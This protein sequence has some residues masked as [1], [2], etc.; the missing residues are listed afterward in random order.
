[1]SAIYEGVRRTYEKEGLP[2]TEV[3]FEKI[4][5]RTLGAYLQWKMVEMMYIAKL[6]DVNA[7]D[8]P[9]VEGYKEETRHILRKNS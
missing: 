9:G 7:F 5:E 4:N 2:F 3:T 6:L 8:Q 1:M